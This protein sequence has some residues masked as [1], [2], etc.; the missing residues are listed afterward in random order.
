M[1]TNAPEQR[2]FPRTA[3]A[4]NRDHITLMHIKTQA[5]ENYF[6]F[7]RFLQAPHFKHDAISV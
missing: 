6:F 2:T 4:D 3:G 5:I 1:K 7:K